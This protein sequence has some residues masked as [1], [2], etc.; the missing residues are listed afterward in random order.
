MEGTFLRLFSTYDTWLSRRLHEYCR[1]SFLLRG[2]VACLAADP[3]TGVGSLLELRPIQRHSLKSLDTA[4][5]LLVLVQQD[6]LSLFD[7]GLLLHT[8]T[9]VL[10]GQTQ[11]AGVWFCVHLLIQSLSSDRRIL[12]FDHRD[13]RKLRPWLRRKRLQHK[14]NVDYTWFPFQKRLRPLVQDRDVVWSTRKNLESVLHILPQLLAHTPASPRVIFALRIVASLTRRCR[15]EES[16]P[17][18]QQ[19]QESI[20]QYLVDEAGL[21]RR[22]GLGFGFVRA[23]NIYPIRQTIHRSSHT[24]FRP[25]RM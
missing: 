11:A 25:R 2:Q 21:K 5:M 23:S 12:F 22:K 20:I 10:N 9:C 7:G 3:P 4:G 14:G 6:W 16:Y 17:H 19:F 13:Q 24:K 18:W 8:Q 15:N 1:K